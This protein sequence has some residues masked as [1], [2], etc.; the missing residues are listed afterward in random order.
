MII[1]N[2]ETKVA[3]NNFSGTTT[4]M[5]LDESRTDVLLD[6]LSKGIYSNPIGAVVR[7]YSS[8]AW[9]AHVEAKN[10]DSPIIVRLNSDDMGSYFEVQDFGVGLSPERFNKV[11]KNYLGTTKDT[12]ADMLGAFGLGSKSALSYTS[13]FYITSNHDGTSY[14]YVMAKSGSSVDIMTLFTN[15]TDKPNGVSIKIYLVNKYDESSFEQE[16]ANQLRY[17]KNVVFEKYG[18]TDNNFNSSKIFEMDGLVFNPHVSDNLHINFGTVP[19]PIDF[20]QLGIDTIFLPFGINVNPNEVSI[21]PSRETLNYTS[22][23]KNLIRAKIAEMTETVYKMYKDTQNTHYST[24]QNFIEKYSPEYCY[25]TVGDDKLDVTQVIRKAENFSKAKITIEGFGITN[26]SKV[27]A[28]QLQSLIKPKSYVREGVSRKYIKRY[29]S[30]SNGVFKPSNALNYRCVID[31]LGNASKQTRCYISE[32]YQNKDVHLVSLADYKDIFATI[33]KFPKVSEGIQRK[34]ADS[35]IEKFTAAC[36]LDKL[37]EIENAITKEWTKAY[38]DDLKADRISKVKGEMSLTMLE[39]ENHAY[40]PKYKYYVSRET[41]TLE[42]IKEDYN[43]LIIGTDRAELDVF[44]VHMGRALSVGYLAPKNFELC[45]SLDNTM[46]IEEYLKK[47]WGHR[48]DDLASAMYMKSNFTAIDGE[49]RKFI[50]E[51]VDT[52][53]LELEGSINDF[54]SFFRVSEAN[55]IMNNTTLRGTA[56]NTLK[57]YIDDYTLLKEKFSYLDAFNLYSAL[58]VKIARSYTKLEGVAELKPTEEETIEQIVVN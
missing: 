32:L 48:L 34:W 6:M 42:D 46:T 18:S 30:S 3:S 10:T 25:L 20:K 53:M 22:D 57:E 50:K 5:G 7:E 15:P 16:I 19:Y 9:D 13:S 17:F 40:S 37:S 38:K 35:F 23:T 54:K 29:S 2:K 26:F 43:L 52:E 21:S 1:G 11:F 4:K 51:E 36:N 12:N 58:G 27:H 56:S 33:K 44:K 24:I 28:Y 41:T 31:D 39:S 14:G 45:K 55:Y 8:N 49:T 47:E